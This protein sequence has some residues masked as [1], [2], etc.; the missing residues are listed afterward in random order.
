M[1]AY[2]SILFA[3][4]RKVTQEKLALGLLVFDRSAVYFKYSPKKISVLNNFLPKDEYQLIR[5]SI[6]S[7]KKEILSH[8]KT[9][10]VENQELYLIDHSGFSMDYINY[11]SRYK[12]NLITYSEPK[13]IVLDVSP[14][15]VMKLYD[16]LIGIDPESHS[17]A[18]LS[19]IEQLTIQYRGQIE[20]HFTVGY[21]VTS[22]RVPALV[23]PIRVDLVGKNEIDVLVRT[24][25][26]SA[27]PEKI[28]NEV[29]TFYMLKEAYKKNN[30]KFKDF[31]I[32][33]EPQHKL[34]NQ[35]AIWRKLKE[36]RDFTYLDFSEADKLREYAEE[37][38]VR[39]VVDN[40]QNDDSVFGP[41]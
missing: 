40:Q 10:Q 12:N 4:L 1:S 14:E 28:S 33:E 16:S 23:V 34:K 36:S 21:T 2:Y 22:E 7:V 24:I 6:K 26:M 25:D 20:D 15:N 31:I 9:I 13:P 38:N 39:P 19:P 29:A 27:G 18:K 17:H 30:I 37:H 32:A 11:L 35:Y 3:S 5:Q 8:S 41:F